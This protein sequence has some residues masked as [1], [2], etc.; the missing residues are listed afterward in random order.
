M[1]EKIGASKLV[2]SVFFLFNLRSMDME[3]TKAQV[4]LG[5]QAQAC[6]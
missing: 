6:N 1:V 2:R 5:L 3:I 4:S